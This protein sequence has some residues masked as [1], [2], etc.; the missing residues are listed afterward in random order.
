MIVASGVPSS[1][2]AAAAMP[3]IAARRCSLES[4]IFVADSASDWTVMWTFYKHGD[5]G[6]FK[7]TLAIQILTG[8]VTM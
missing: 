5:M 3:P 2:A 6:W 4:A 7:A 1:C 8:L